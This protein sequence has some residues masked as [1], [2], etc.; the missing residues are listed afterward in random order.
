MIGGAVLLIVQV[1]DGPL[2]LFDGALLLALLACLS[3]LLSGREFARWGC[4]FGGHFVACVVYP[5]QA[6]HRHDGVKHS[7]TRCRGSWC[8]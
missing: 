4:V 2:G 8:R 6:T 5:V 3:V 1:L 7:P